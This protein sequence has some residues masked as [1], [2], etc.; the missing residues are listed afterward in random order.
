M[1]KRSREYGVRAYQKDQNGSSLF[2]RFAYFG[3]VCALPSSPLLLLLLSLL[4][5]G[6]SLSLLL[7]TE[8]GDAVAFVGANA[9]EDAEGAATYSVRTFLAGACK[10]RWVFSRTMFRMTTKN[11]IMMMMK[12]K[13]RDVMLLRVCV[14]ARR[15][16]ERQDEG[17]ILID[18][19][20]YNAY[21]EKMC[22]VP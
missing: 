20:G 16:G 5:T 4:T 15:N 13:Q 7:T 10:P 3:F 19:R 12:M 1:N 11:A 6:S 8:L 21:N 18:D 22:S 9:T 2:T 17:E 14:R